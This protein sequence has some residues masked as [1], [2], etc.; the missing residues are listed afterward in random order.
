MD[1]APRIALISAL[2]QS[3]PPALAAM[4]DVWPE[5]FAFNLIDDS[6]AGDLAAQGEITAGIF[7]RFL[8][9][10]RYATGTTDGINPTAGILFTCSA[11]RPAIDKVK[12]D[13]SVPVVSP[14]E[15]AFEEALDICANCLGGG[16]IGILLTFAGSLAPL[17]A[18]LTAIAQAR[19][20]VVP[21]LFT[22]VADGALEAL[23]RGDGE[24]HDQFAAA[25]AV[26]LPMVDVIVIGQFSMARAAP[27]VAAL[28]NEPILTTPE[29]AARKLRRLVEGRSGP[30]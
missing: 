24:I 13:L 4:R 9:L 1:H 30:A 6:L 2:D 29:A 22:A 10:G 25:A 26:T 7:D 14:N 16:R 8:A 17:R 23:R 28:R 20:Q 27:V 3:S 5:A 19:G 11:F 18:E 15:G 12:A 21:E